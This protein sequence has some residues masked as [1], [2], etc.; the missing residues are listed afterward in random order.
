MLKADIVVA[1]TG[2]HLNVLGDIDFSVD[3]RPLV[4]ADTVTY[5]GLMSTGVPNLAYVF[6]YSARHGLCARTWCRRSSA[7]CWPT[8]RQRGAEVVEPRLRAED[9]EMRLGPW[10]DQDNFN[11]GYIN[12]GLHLLPKGGDKIEWRHTHDYYADKESIPTADLEDGTL[13]YR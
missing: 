12:R 8:M 6:G 5:R 13:I 1:A 10:V 4:L 3:G 2:F 9:A 11:P 7:G